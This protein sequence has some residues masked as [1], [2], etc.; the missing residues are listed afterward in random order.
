MSATQK[1]NAQPL[2]FKVRRPV[3]RALAVQYVGTKT[4]LD[5]KYVSWPAD[6]Y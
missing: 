1:S 5:I 4:E 2:L 6:R 3:E